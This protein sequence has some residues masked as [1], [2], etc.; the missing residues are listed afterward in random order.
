MKFPLVS[1]AILLLCA[2]CTGPAKEETNTGSSTTMMLPSILLNASFSTIVVAIK[3][4]PTDAGYAFRYGNSPAIVVREGDG[5]IAY[6]DESPRPGCALS[7][8]EG[9]LKSPCTGSKFDP[10]TGE[11][12]LGPAKEPLKKIDIFVQNEAIYV[13]NK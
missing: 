9:V 7:L 2:G 11:V 6:L 8:T 4:F 3:E 5:Y 1:L 10:A 13:L 12:I